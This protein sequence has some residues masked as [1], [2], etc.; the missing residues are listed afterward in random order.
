MDKKVKKILCNDIAV[1]FE[2]DSEYRQMFET[3]SEYRQ[4]FEKEN[5][6]IVFDSEGMLTE[7]AYVAYISL[8]IVQTEHAYCDIFVGNNYPIAFEWDTK[9]IDWFLHL[10]K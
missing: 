10:Y 1:M 3:D 9:A 4:M 6:L 2:T 7:G 8:M 5:N